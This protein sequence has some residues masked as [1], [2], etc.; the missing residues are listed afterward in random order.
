VSQRV[1]DLTN[2][3]I[4][5]FKPHHVFRNFAGPKS[6]NRVVQQAKPNVGPYAWIPN[7]NVSRRRIPNEIGTFFTNVG[8]TGM[9]SVGVSPIDWGLPGSSG[10]GDLSGL[11][12]AAGANAQVGSAGAAG[13]G[14]GGMIG[15]VHAN[16]R[17]KVGNL[18][19][20]GGV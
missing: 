1:L 2:K 6:E 4:S 13:A 7:Q 8:R 12:G 9:G 5:R 10:L 11:P 20:R 15:N 19:R 3:G 18:I 16:L 14:I 17:R